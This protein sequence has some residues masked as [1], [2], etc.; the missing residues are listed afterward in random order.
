MTAVAYTLL[1]DGDPVAGDILDA[2]E[3][4]E[5][6]THYRMADILRLTLRIEQK[7]DGSGWIV[8]DDN[9]FPRLANLTLLVTIGASVPSVLIDAYVVE[10]GA[11]FSDDPGGSEFTV[12]AMDG[13]VL[14]NLEEKV[15]RWPDMSDS[16][17][18]T[19]IFGEYG[20]LPIVDNTQPTRTAADTTVTQRDTD[21]R[22]L[23]HLAERNGFELFLSPTFVPGVVEGHFH[24][25]SLDLPPQG[26]LSIAMGDQTNVQRLDATYEMVRP[27]TAAA[28]GVDART[29]DDQAGDAASA[30]ETGLGDRALLNGDRPRR[31]RLRPAGLA[32]TGELQILAQAA[33]NRSAWAVTVKGELDTAVYGDILDTAKNV[34]VRGAGEEFSGYYYVQSVLHRFTAEGH[35]QSFTLSRNALALTG[36]EVFVPTLGLPG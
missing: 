8:A 24:A 15:R 20:M 18:A 29:L 16:T 14:M 4:V 19:V 25:P 7:N 34:A 1:I 35:T 5:V 28:S 10:A 31:V 21:I 26:V 36:A 32:E 17:I 2:I 12:V 3:S 13:T 9:V 30:D 23:R 22:F 33:T 6:E 11:T 27:T